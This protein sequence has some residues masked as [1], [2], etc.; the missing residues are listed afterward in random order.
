MFTFSIPRYA[1]NIPANMQMQM[2]IHLL[3]PLVSEL[4]YPQQTPTIV[5]KIP[6]SDNPSKS[7][8]SKNPYNVGV[9]HDSASPERNT[10]KII[11]E[12]H[13]KPTVENCLKTV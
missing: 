1:K 13:C 7:N 9:A 3:Q 10:I 6:V 2:K 8:L 12:I 11:Y 5:F 4:L